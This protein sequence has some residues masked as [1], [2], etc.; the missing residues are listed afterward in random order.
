MTHVDRPTLDDD[1]R[2]IG[3][4]LFK[5]LKWSAP[6]QTGAQK[7]EEGVGVGVSTLLVPNYSNNLSPTYYTI[8]TYFIYLWRHEHAHI[9]TQAYAETHTNTK[10]ER[11][12]RTDSDRQRET[13]QTDWQQTEWQKSARQRE[14]HTLMKR[15]SVRLCD[16]VSVLYKCFF[17]SLW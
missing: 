17:F 9:H 8:K 16:Y 14:T 13:E 2:S 10:T 7:V 4:F 5:L 11:E 6:W 12:R 1:N 3:G 15:E